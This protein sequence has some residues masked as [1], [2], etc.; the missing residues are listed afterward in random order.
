MEKAGGIQHR[1]KEGTKVIPELALFR[2]GL[3]LRCCVPTKQTPQISARSLHKGLITMPELNAKVTKTLNKTTP[4]LQIWRIENME[5]VPV[6]PKAY[7][8][9]YEGDAYVLLST[10]KTGSSFSYD[11]HYWLGNSSSLDEQGAAA[12]YS[13]QMDDHLGGVAVQHREV[14]GYESEVFRGYFRN[15]LIYKKGGV[16]SGMKHVETN[17]YNVQR[18]L[19]VKGKKNVVAA[20]VEMSW[21]SFNQGDVFLLDLGKLIIQWN[22]PESNRMERLKGM[23]VAKDIRDHERGGRAQIGVVDGEA[24]AASP[25]LM[26]VLTYVL[27]PK[28]EI[29]PSIPDAVVDQKLKTSLKLYHVSDVEGNL[30]IQEVATR[31]LTQ[32]LLNHEECY[33]LDQCG[34]RI[35]VWKGRNCS[36]EEKQEAMTRALGF[37]KAKNYPP[38]TGVETENDGSE[39]AVFKQLFQKWTVPNQT[40]GFGKTSS[41]GKVAK[42]EQV[43]FD[44]T[45]LHAKPEMAAQHRMVDDGSGEVQVWRIENL[46]LVPV[47]SRW[48]GH[49]YSGDCYLVLYTYQIYNKIHYIIYI[50]QGR[51][52][53]QDEITA[54]A[55]QAVILD[56]QYNNEPVQV[57]V[58]MGKEPAHL[59]AIFKG[60]MVVYMG[61]TS[62]AGNTDPVPSIRLFQVHGTNEYNTKAFEVPPRAISLNS[63]DV[64]ILKSQTCCYLWYGKGCSGDEREM[65]KSVA[66]LLSRTEKVVIA[67]GQEPTEFWLA[68]GGK[69]QYANNKRLQ[70]ETLSIMPRL[71]ECSNKT[72]TFLATEIPNFTQDDLEDDDVFLLDVWDQVFFWIGKEAN[73]VEKEAA[74]ITAQEY[75]RSHPSGRDL[76][77]PIVIV[78][79]GCEPPTFTGWFLAWDPLKWTDKKTY[80]ELKA[81]LGDDSSLSELTSEIV[82]AKEIFTAN[83]TFAK[84]SVG[85]YP[86]EQL[87][88]MPAE[89]LPKD[90]NPSRKEDYLSEEDFITVFG[91]SRQDYATLPQWKQQA[92]KKEKGLF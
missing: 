40:V 23:N 87:V 62:R 20:E 1:G 52:A 47:E 11:I 36:K 37:I 48:L 4:G 43:K 9:F 49:F 84:L 69:T 42:V 51:H 65:A 17:T 13:T 53:S 44:A 28:K 82:E 16:A 58:T 57:R 61:G 76:D 29:Q 35:Y 90:V 91:V 25:G 14:Q 56:Q 32:D 12:I 77:T 7:G 24:E 78:K 54:S 89:E 55:Y 22:G 8:N 31:P 92:L 83:T 73:E 85:T 34:V 5:M 81:E 75:L 18:L 3:S 59:M 6:P 88:N 45:T 70:E 63:N 21:S 19:M 10:R 86:P 66:D 38:T 64:F 2:Y 74:A 80:E 27:G 33:I 50:W 79:Q 15:G 71:F 46:E 26:K 68:L 60:R 67:E 41:V 30:L 39:S 72:G